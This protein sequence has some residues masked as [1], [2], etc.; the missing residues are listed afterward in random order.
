MSDEQ[1]FKVVVK[2]NGVTVNAGGQPKDGPPHGLPKKL[3]DSDAGNRN[4]Q[5]EALGI[6]TRY[7][8]VPL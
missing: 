4:D 3:A 5:A 1:K 8:V 7:V 2:S 6:E